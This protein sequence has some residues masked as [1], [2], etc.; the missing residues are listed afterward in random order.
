MAV[1]SADDRSVDQH[2]WSGS[3]LKQAPGHTAP[4]VFARGLRNPFG[5]CCGPA[6]S[7]FVTDND[8]ADNPGDE[9]NFVVA[10]HHYGHPFA[11]P[12]ES[13]NAGF[14]EPIV[15]GP[16]TSLWSSPHLSRRAIQWMGMVLFTCATSAWAR[17]IA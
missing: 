15:V 17:L 8:C 4:E 10:G 14:S 2:P 5:L 6:G 1:G 16:N 12:G 3:I 13:R 9:V 11:I 7:L